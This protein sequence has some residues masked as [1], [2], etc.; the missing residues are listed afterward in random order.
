MDCIDW[1]L[2]VDNTNFPASCHVLIAEGNND[3]LMAGR[4]VRKVSM[5]VGL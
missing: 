3:S 2:V 5:L 4:Y 1:I